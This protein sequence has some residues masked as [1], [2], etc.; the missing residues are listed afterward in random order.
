MPPWSLFRIVLCALVLATFAPAHAGL[1]AARTPPPLTQLPKLGADSARTSVSGLSSGGF[2][3]VQYAVTYSA[4]TIGAGIVAGGPYGCGLMGLAA[5]LPCMKGTP[6]GSGSYWA[7][8][9]YQGLG[10]IDPIAHIARQRI[11]LFHGTADSIVGSAT[12]KAVHDFYTDLHVPPANLA[13]IADLPAGHAFLSI[14]LGGACDANADPY[15]NRCKVDDKPYDQP[16][17]ILTQILGQALSARAETLSGKVRSFDQRPYLSP[18]SAM[19]DTGYLYVPA[20][21]RKSG[22]KCAV[23]VVFHGCGQAAK[24]VGDDVYGQLGFNNWADTNGL[25]VL[26]PQVEKSQPLPFNPMGCWDWWGYTGST[27]F[28]TRYGPQLS[29]VRAMVERLGGED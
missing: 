11:Y 29:S 10:A 7:A 26:Y 24:Y 4:S 6:S 19:A 27:A 15:V 20:G 22:A 9:W 23:H 21:C 14:A 3:A 17:A 1:A 13:Y 18:F 25:I 8:N 28:A 5:T 2:M 16:G 12:M